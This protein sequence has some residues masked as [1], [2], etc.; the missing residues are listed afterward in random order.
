MLKNGFVVA[1]SHSF[2]E[3][4]DADPDQHQ[5]EKSDIDLHHSEKKKW[6][7][8]R[9]SRNRIR[10]KVNRETQIRI[11]VMRIR[12]T[13]IKTHSDLLGVKKAEFKE[14]NIFMSR[15]PHSCVSNYRSA[16]I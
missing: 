13:G 16:L 2:N 15:D 8:I 1:Y 14:K 10:I 5:S 11:N 7:Q 4:K 9:K 6:I 12:N 3:G